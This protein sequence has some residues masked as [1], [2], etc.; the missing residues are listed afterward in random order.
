M[1]RYLIVVMTLLSL[2]TFAQTKMELVIGKPFPYNER[3]TL[4]HPKSKTMSAEDF[5]GKYL[6][7]Q[8]FS[9][10]CVLSFKGLPLLDT[11]QKQND[12]NLNILLISL[13]DNKI[14]TLY[15]KFKL[16]YK[17][18][19]KMSVD[20]ALLST[21]R[22]YFLPTYIWIDPSGIVQAVSGP[23]RVTRANVQT[24]ISG[25][26][27]SFSDLIRPSTF[28]EKNDFLDNGN[29]GA[30]SNYLFRS[31]LSNWNES[32]PYYIPRE[33]KFDANTKKFAAL[34]ANLSM[35]LRYA[36]FGRPFIEY[37]DSLNGS[38]WPHPVFE[39]NHAANQSLY[40][41][42]VSYKT[43]PVPKLSELLKTA[44]SQTLG[45]DV[46]IEIRGMPYYEISFD[47]VKQNLIRSDG[48]KAVHRHSHASLDDSNITIADL[49]NR[50]EYYNTGDIPF[51]TTGWFPNHFSIKLG[52]I[53]T[54][55]NDFFEGLRMLGFTITKKY[56]S[57]QVIVVH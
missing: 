1:I 38:V 33:L 53:L 42:A 26:K 29:G 46:R 2:S 49:I 28:N 12:K 24:F 56:K 27:L 7:L 32:I 45:R 25:Q 37:A 50:L 36:Y 9:S 6:L 54:D 23:D 20:S 15:K 57:M 11:L 21:L 52:R 34:G 4:S 41:Y 30:D 43:S 17:L 44:I 19:L 8:L 18:E 55:Q 14:E 16:H 10:Q 40:C 31:V 35:L 47:S 22:F 13:R 48:G 3:F 51:I 39:F 5:K